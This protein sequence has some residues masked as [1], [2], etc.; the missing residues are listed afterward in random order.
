MISTNFHAYNSINPMFALILLSYETMSAR[1][2]FWCLSKPV[3]NR[4]EACISLLNKAVYTALVA[5]SRPKSESITYGR[6]DGR[7]DTPS[8]R[9]ASKQLKT[10]S[11]NNLMGNE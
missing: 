4:A 6:T 1:V 8:Y 7:T 3:Q 10:T 9:V 5:L 11:G 2:V